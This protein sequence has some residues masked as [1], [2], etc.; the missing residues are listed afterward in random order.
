[1]LG[2]AVYEGICV[3]VQLAPVLLASVLGKQLSPFDELASVDPL[4]YK[5][6]TYVKHYNDS[7]DLEDL[8]LTF[9]FQEE[10]L[11]KVIIYSCLIFLD[12]EILDLYA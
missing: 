1:M 5:N 6:L 4:L 8:A 3:D 10:F 12:L 11:G 7:D 2:K 9:S